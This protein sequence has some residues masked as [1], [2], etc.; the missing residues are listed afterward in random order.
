MKLWIAVL[1]LNQPEL[2]QQFLDLLR[3]N[4]GEARLPLLLVDNGSTPPVRDWLKG[5]RETSYGEDVVIRTPENIGVMP[6]LNLAWG[7][8]KD[9]S[10]YIFFPHN[11]L[12]LYEKGWGD[13]LVRILSNLPDC[14]VAGFYGA[15]GLGVP[16]IYQTPYQM[17]Q[18]VRGGNVSSCHRMD[19]AVHGFRPVE[20]ET[21]KVAVMDGFSLI[22]KTELLN[23]LGGFDRAYPPHHNYDND[24]CLESLDKG[25]SNYV[26][27]M[28]AQHLG[29][30]TDVGE[31]WNKPFG[32]EKHEIHRD[33]HP[34]LYEKWSPKNVQSGLHR[35]SLPVRI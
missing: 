26:I 20:G 27:A 22:V 14:G 1:V 32:K 19:A 13:K 7:Y 30:R 35:I 15:K 23:K 31:A 3:E 6:G 28:D 8:L 34:V 29:G 5:L 25:Y 9:K 24:I 4:E 12:M 21:E 10:D 18:L 16:G 2:T 11:D 33:A 17:S